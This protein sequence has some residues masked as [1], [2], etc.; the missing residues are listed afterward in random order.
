MKLNVFE[1]K[2]FAFT[3]TSYHFNIGYEKVVFISI[4]TLPYTVLFNVY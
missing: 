3:D 2:D 4:W 1:I